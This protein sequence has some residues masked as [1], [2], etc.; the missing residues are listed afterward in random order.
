MGIRWTLWL[1]SKNNRGLGPLLQ[2]RSYRPAP[3]GPLLQARSYKGI[4]E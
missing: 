1:A 2:A 3:T 4:P